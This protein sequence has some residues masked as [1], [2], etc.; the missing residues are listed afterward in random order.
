MTLHAFKWYKYAFT[1]LMSNHLQVSQATKLCVII[2]EMY[3]YLQE[4]GANNGPPA[5]MR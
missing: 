4:D 1:V 5:G 3:M 2:S